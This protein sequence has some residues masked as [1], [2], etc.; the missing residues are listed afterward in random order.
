MSDSYRTRYIISD[1]VI[2]Q[3]G[4]DSASRANVTYIKAQNE[5]SPPRT[6]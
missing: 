3:T 5:D 2:M 6:S 1:C 4:M